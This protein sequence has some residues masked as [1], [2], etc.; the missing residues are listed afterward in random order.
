MIR[1]MPGI[2]FRIWRKAIA[3]CRGGGAMARLKETGRVQLVGCPRKDRQGAWDLYWLLTS[4]HKL[5]GSRSLLFW[6]VTPS[7]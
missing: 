7:A 2:V 5:P 6:K 1:M 4:F 3:R